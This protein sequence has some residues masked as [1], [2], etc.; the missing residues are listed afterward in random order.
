MASKFKEII[1]VIKLKNTF[2]F[3]LKFNK[4]KK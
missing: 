3:Y 4:K 2:I 1:V